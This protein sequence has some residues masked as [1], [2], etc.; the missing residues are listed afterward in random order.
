MRP[1]PELVRYLNDV[2]AP[3]SWR[4]AADLLPNFAV[5]KV[6]NQLD[7]VPLIGGL[8]NVFFEFERPPSV[9][10]VSDVLIGVRVPNSGVHRLKADVLLTDPLPDSTAVMELSLFMQVGSSA[11]APTS[12]VRVE[13]QILSGLARPL[14]LFFNPPLFFQ[15]VA[16]EDVVQ[17]ILEAVIGSELANQLSGL[18]TFRFAREPD[19]IGPS[20]PPTIELVR[21]PGS[22]FLGSMDPAAPGYIDLLVVSDGCTSADL[23]AFD[24]LVT[25]L[26]RRLAPGLGPAPAPFQQSR[27]A[28]RVW[29]LRLVSGQPGTRLERTLFPVR[30]P[31]HEL[32]NFSNLARL[33]E[34]GLTATSTFAHHPMV[35][36]VSRITDADRAQADLPA[37]ANL[38]AFT[39]GPYVAMS[40]DE[41]V[42]TILHE[43]GHT[44]LGRYL[45][46]EYPDSARACGGTPRDKLYK[47]LEPAPRNASTTP[48]SGWVKWQPWSGSLF[49]QGLNL[50]VGGY[51]HDL[52]TF[53][54][55]ATCKMRCSSETEFCQI[56]REELARGLLAHS[57]ARVG[58]ATAAGALDATVEYVAPF[59]EP[60]RGVRVTGGVAAHLDVFL[61][62]VSTFPTRLRV[63]VVGS[64]VPEPWEIRWSFAGNAGGTT[65]FLSGVEH[66]IDALPGARME[67]RVR[68]APPTPP[69]LAADRGVLE[70]TAVFQ[71]D[72]ERRVSP[73]QLL[74][75]TDLRQSLM[76]VGALVTPQIDPAT[77]HVTTPQPLWVEAR[78]GGIQGFELDTQ[79]AFRI[80]GP[81]GLQVSHDS[82]FTRAGR[83]RRFTVDRM[84]PAGR[85]TWSATTRWFGLSSS[86]VQ[87]PRSPQGIT[88]EIGG[89]PFVESPV[90]P[91]DPFA[92]QLVEPLTFP[93]RPVGLQAS[94]WHPADRQVGFEFEF[95]RDPLPLDGTGT[96]RTTLQR[97]D[98]NDA[99]SV[100]VTGRISFT[101]FPQPGSAGDL[102]RWRVRAFDDAGRQSGWVEGRP[103]LLFLAPG[104]PQDLEE[105]TG[106]LEQI[107][108]PSLLDPQGPFD[109]PRLF[110]IA[111]RPGPFLDD[112]PT[113]FSRLKKLLDRP[114]EIR[115]Y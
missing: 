12:N 49:E 90:P 80:D 51:D 15:M 75:P 16:L 9:T 61:S 23:L 98:P 74:P 89:L 115:Q 55:A 72:R 38:T 17:R 113:D 96:Q 99:D 46:D 47:G 50:H 1:T 39:Q 94:S 76:P 6:S 108:I 71:F 70:T 48:F 87:A 102:Y 106:L 8:G 14:L 107:G 32:V 91:V 65:G 77:G 66:E 35:I 101:L 29:S 73:Q 85:Y 84:L 27:S 97:R 25:E 30:T 95:K 40:L 45:A 4:P 114:R 110:V 100:A 13:F 92:L 109:L 58:T 21:P 19:L 60:L 44:P 33:A 34:I 111:D 63:K 53:R 93:S 67:L 5:S 52:G 57:H 43:L 37:G 86:T 31:Q 79:I 78:N 69:L 7:D 2:F 59:T 28:I 81:G 11:P 56:C 3:E 112:R 20:G 41:D 24:A 68:H 82:P 83:V 105:M 22:A 64:T 18:Q 62:D 42:D 26:A 103:F 36:L 10:V 104:R 54:F 88:W